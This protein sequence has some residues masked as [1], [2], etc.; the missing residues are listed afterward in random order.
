M[1]LSSRLAAVALVVVCGSFDLSLAQR[2]TLKQKDASTVILEPRI[3]RNPDLRGTRRLN[4]DDSVSNE[5]ADNPWSQLQD[6]DRD[7]FIRQICGDVERLFT[8]QYSCT[9]TPTA[10][11]QLSYVCDRYSKSQVGKAT[12]GTRYE[13]AFVVRLFQTEFATPMSVCLTDMTYQAVRLGRFV[14]FGNV[15]LEATL[16]LDVDPLQRDVSA[17]VDECNLQLGDA[18]TC[19]TCGECPNGADG[20]YVDCEE[21]GAG[22]PICLSNAIPFFGAAGQT[23]DRDIFDALNLMAMMEKKVEEMAMEEEAAANPVPIAPQPQQQESEETVSSTPTTFQEQPTTMNTE[24]TVSSTPTTET[25]TT[26]TEEQ[27]YAENEEE[28]G[29][30][31]AAAGE[32]PWWVLLTNKGGS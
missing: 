27:T 11:F 30:D 16:T 25:S 29:G 32:I 13:G 8:S 4:M 10:F 6:K 9:C 18:G 14:P 31:T 21:L 5:I 1:K 26:A 7:L 20:F 23:D 12:Y 15:C 22:A 2:E 17:R 28:N 3:Q 24:E 19:N